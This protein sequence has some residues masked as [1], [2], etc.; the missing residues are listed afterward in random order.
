[1]KINRNQLKA[2]VKKELIKE[3]PQKTEMGQF[4]ASKS[5]KRVQSAGSKISSASRAI[6][7][8]AGDQTGAMRN[9]LYEISEFVDKI[10]D[11]LS[12]IGI[13][14]EGSS[15]ADSLPTIQE[16]RQ[17]QKSIQKLER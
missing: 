13:L 16:L 4:A 11:T 17:L 15:V 5:G 10:G 8:V 6:S 3:S 7:E 1:M 2:I 12:G 14:E 9:T